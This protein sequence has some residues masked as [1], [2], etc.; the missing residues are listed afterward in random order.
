MILKGSQRGTGQNLAAHLLKTDDNEHVLVHELRGFAA[1]DLHGAFKEIE[2]VSHG[3]KCQQYLFSLSLSPPEDAR[4]P[5]SDFEDA[6]ERIERKLGLNGQPRAV[7]FHEKEGRRHAHCVWSR[8]D[9]DTMTARPMSFFK[10]KLMAVSRDLYLEHGWKMPRGLENSRERNPTN[11]SLA[12]WQQAKRQDIDPR[13]LKQAMQDCWN[14]SDNLKSFAQSLQDRGFFLARG[15]KRGFVVLDHVGEVWSLPRMLDIKTKDVRARLGDGENLSSVDDTQKMIGA[16]M[17][18]SIRRHIAESRER[19]QSRS[20]KLGEAKEEM[21]RQHR[22]ARQKLEERQRI[23]WDV[24]TRERAARLPTGF[25]GLWHRLTGQYQKLR[26]VNEAEAEASRERQA[27][28]RQKLI[29]KQ[30]EQRAGLQTQFKE[31]RSK[32]AQQLLALRADIGRYLKFSRGHEEQSRARETSIGLRL[33][34]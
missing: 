16:R 5:A 11:F 7:V 21:T 20:A 28:E 2:A 31:L 12:E 15:D 26:A 18:P 25:R 1:D 34:R 3:T 33:E 29:D 32:Q 13:W 14:R 9:A 30:L 19:F 8:I 27:Q 23:E 10:Q 4:V 24:Q 22:A 6:I 17:T